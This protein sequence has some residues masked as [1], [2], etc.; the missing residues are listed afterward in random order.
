MDQHCNEGVLIV[1]SLKEQWDTFRKE[2]EKDIEI[3]KE[4]DK[5]ISESRDMANAEVRQQTIFF[6]NFMTSETMYALKSNQNQGV[7]H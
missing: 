3:H 7:E 2:D 6:A 4:I 5:V 1:K